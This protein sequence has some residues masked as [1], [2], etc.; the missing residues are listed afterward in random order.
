MAQ[1]KLLLID[2]L[3]LGLAPRAVELLGESL[4]KVN[5]E[6]ISILLVEQDVVTAF[7]LA[8][9]AYVIE[10]GRVGIFGPTQALMQDPSVKAAY[11][12]F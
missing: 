1:P 11:M 12:G 3:S 2:E 4:L 6:G 5:R 10:S 9:T 7:E 8:S